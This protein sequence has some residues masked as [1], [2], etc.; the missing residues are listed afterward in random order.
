MTVK[1]ELTIWLKDTSAGTIWV[2]PETR[3]TKI[4]V[5]IS[6]SVAD[7]PISIGFVFRNSKGHFIL[8]GIEPNTAGTSSEAECHGLLAA[9]KRGVC[10]QLKHVEIKSDSKEAIDRLSSWKAKQ[11]IMDSQKLPG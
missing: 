11:L 5:D 4:N 6:F 1:T 10:K 3:T 7:S 8:A 2:P 9:V